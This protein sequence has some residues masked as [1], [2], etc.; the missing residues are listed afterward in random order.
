M[1]AKYTEI[2]DKY[3]SGELKG[4]ELNDFNEKL[5]SDSQLRLEL[6]LEKELNVAIED[7]KVIGFRE[8]VTDVRASMKE[9][10][11]KDENLS[12]VIS[13]KKIDRQWYLL[14][15]SVALLFG[16]TIYFVFLFD[17][18]YTNE[19]LYAQYFKPYPS[20]ISIRTTDQVNQDTV[21][22][23]FMEYEKSNF[24]EAINYFNSVLEN[25]SSNIP[26]CF[27]LGISYMET[28][29]FLKAE[30]CFRNIIENKFNIFSEEAKW[31]LALTWLKTDEKK[32]Q[33]KIHQ[34]LV[35]IISEKG[36]RAEDA[37]DLLKELGY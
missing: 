11:E 3:L 4:Q 33:Q 27:Y 17:Q 2:I 29:A 8:Q 35:E 18:T 1:E 36:D 9:E 13:F 31:Y 34:L 16:L 22:L 21:L 26:V 20:D 30:N 10:K 37:S 5:N 28:G 32:Q 14:A 12:R 23:G 7:E 6:N 25:D 24:D 19:E 15:A